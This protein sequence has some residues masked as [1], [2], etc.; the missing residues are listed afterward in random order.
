MITTIFVCFIK[1]FLYNNFHIKICGTDLLNNFWII[2]RN[3]K[4]NE[5]DL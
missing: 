4:T 1:T 5:R 3:W 2:A